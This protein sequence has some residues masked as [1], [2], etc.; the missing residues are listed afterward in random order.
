M[1]RGL[2]PGTGDRARLTP[3]RYAI[4]LTHNRPELLAQCVAA[5]RLQAD[6]TIIIDNASEPA[7]APEDFP[8]E[9]GGPFLL[10][11]DP[12]QPPNLSYLWNRGFDAVSRLNNSPQWDV[13]VLCD[14]VTVPEGWFDTVSTCMRDHGAAAGSTHQWR[15]VG[16]PILKQL[17]DRDLQNRMCGWAFVLAGEKRIRADEDLMW[18]WC[19]TDLD[20]Q[21]RGN[22]G[23]VICPGPVAKN[24][25]P[26][27]WTSRIPLLN[28]RSGL[29]SEVFAR[30]WG[31]RPW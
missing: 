25:H 21:A 17:P 27:E 14:D 12:L 10:I 30:K 16:Q 9:G 28:Q 23:M 5:I 15:E 8:L 13:A 3:P 22:G 24:I 19:D 18:W 31:G 2:D 7:V 4:I 1:G 20:W 29:D 6:V 26:N 11:N